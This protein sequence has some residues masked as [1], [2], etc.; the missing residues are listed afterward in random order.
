[1]SLTPRQAELLRYIARYQN[2]NGGISPSYREAA[3]DM[4][5]KSASNIAAMVSHLVEQGF[6]R[7]VRQG[8]RSIKIIK[9]PRASK[10]AFVQPDNR[11]PHCSGVISIPYKGKV[12]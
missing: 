11:C 8:R 6:I 7:K 4:E 9:M 3:A 1:M 2:E 12:S 10:V 5:L